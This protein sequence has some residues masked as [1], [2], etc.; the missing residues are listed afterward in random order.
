MT[1]FTEGRHTAEHILSEASGMRS[2]E[3]ITVLSGQDLAAGT[4]L[5]KVVTG[6]AVAAA[7]A[8]NTGN[9]AMGAITV[10]EPAKAGVYKLTIIEPGANVG[11][12]IVEDPDGIVIGNGDVASAFSAGGLAFT[13]ADGAT[14][15]VAG[16]QFNITVSVSAEKYKAWDKDNTDG[17][18]VVA[19]VLLAAVDATGGD[20]EGVA[21]VRDCEVNYNLLTYPTGEGTQATAGLKAIG[22]IARS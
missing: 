9:G 1:V 16:D 4:V 21:H 3:N 20:A 7:V 19:G 22:I 14:D 5:G 11:A 18:L 17:A 12:F 13:L 10:S 15:F 8:G 2:R 6:S